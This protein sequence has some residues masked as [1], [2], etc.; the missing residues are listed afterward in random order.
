[1]QAQSHII[2]AMLHCNYKAWRL[3]KE[4]NIDADE[5]RVNKQEIPLKTAKQQAQRLSTDVEALLNNEA[6]PPFYKIPHCSECRF[7]KSC[8][9]K[10]VERDCI[11][12]LPS[13]SLKSLLKYHNKGIT[14]ITQLSYL[15]KP[16]R[17]P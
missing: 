12:L 14:T 2:E 9:Q 13:M 8:H 15:F 1:M 4:K 16:R 6:P 3:A 7:K 10:L 11:S 5:F 17:S